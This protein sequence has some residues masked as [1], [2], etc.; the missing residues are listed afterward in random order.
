LKQ[1]LE[2]LL[3]QKETHAGEGIERLDDMLK[4]PISQT[5]KMKWKCSAK[6]ENYFLSR[7]FMSLLQ[8]NRIGPV[9]G[10]MC[11]LFNV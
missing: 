4:K 10:L 5:L 7:G 2:Y 11:G 6:T 8:Q 9:I 3:K 1:L